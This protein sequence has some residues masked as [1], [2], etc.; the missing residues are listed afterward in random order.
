MTNQMF[1]IIPTEFYTSLTCDQGLHSSSTFP[2]F[3][4]EPLHL[5]SQFLYILNLFSKHLLCFFALNEN[6]SSQNTTYAAFS[7]GGIGILLT[8]HYYYYSDIL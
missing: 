8:P 1:T 7:N 2:N 3:S 6:L 4:I 5:H